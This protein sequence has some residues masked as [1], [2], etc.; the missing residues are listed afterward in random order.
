[1]LVGCLMFKETRTTEKVKGLLASCEV[2]CINKEHLLPE[3]FPYTV[4][5]TDDV[6]TLVQNEQ[7]L[8][9]RERVL[10]LPDTEVKL[11]S[12]HPIIQKY[13]HV[14]ITQG[15]D[16]KA[17]PSDK[18]IS[19]MNAM[20]TEGLSLLHHLNY[21]ASVKEFELSSSEQRG[22][23]RDE[24]SSYIEKLVPAL[25]RPSPVYVQYATEI[26]DELLMNS[27]WDA[28]P[29]RAS[30]SRKQPVTLKPN[31]TVKVR[32]AF[33]GFKFGISVRD[34]YGSFP[35]EL[36]EKYMNS[37]FSTS[38]QKS[39]LQS[40]TH[41]A[42]IGMFMILTRASEVTINVAYGKYTEVVV[43]LNF[44]LGPKNMTQGPKTFQFFNL[45]STQHS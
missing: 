22:W 20:Q 41:G 36:C 3:H 39:V 12:E 15:Q 44:S 24:L 33:D 5:M 28:C 37:L 40:E 19:I 29:D 38:E 35:A 14:V 13:N 10:F 17:F 11:M 6:D 26:Q 34:R 27:I 43:V 16:P 25:P 21:G 32:W 31:E 8:A 18:V 1:V 45:G 23:F 4:L 42:G 9:A 7:L 30:I 2:D